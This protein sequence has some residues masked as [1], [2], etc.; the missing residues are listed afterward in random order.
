[1]QL[2][3]RQEVAGSRRNQWVFRVLVAGYEDINYAERLSHDPQLRVIVA[4]KI[5]ERSAAL[6]WPLQP[7]SITT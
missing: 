6:T 1:V 5:W 2:A 7:A 4:E 3:S